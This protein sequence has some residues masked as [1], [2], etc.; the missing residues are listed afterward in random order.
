MSRGR[1]ADNGTPAHAAKIG[2]Q[3]FSS[4]VE[5]LLSPGAQFMWTLSPKSY[6][7]AFA[8]IFATLV[9]IGIASYVMSD[10]FATSEESVIHTHEVIFELKS[11]SAD[12]IEAEDARR[13]FVMIGDRTLLID[14]DEAVHN[15]PQRLN[16]LEI[17]TV[18]NLRQQ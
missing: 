5:F 8:A 14:Y 4:V 15:L 9:G 6:K 1:I 16:R 11:A 13:G 7:T 10:R 17:L 3:L 18:D 2:P 12:L